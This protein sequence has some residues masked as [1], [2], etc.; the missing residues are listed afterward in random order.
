MYSRILTPLD[1]SSLSEQVLPYASSLA[2][3]LSLPM[4]LLY[5]IEPEVLTI[6]RVVNPSLHYEEMATHR[7]RHARNYVDPVSDGLQRAGVIVDVEIPQGEPAESIVGCA[8]K[9]AAT[10]ITMSSHGRSGI[11]RWWIG[12]VSDKVL[13]LTQNPMLVIRAEDPPQRPPE[14]NFTRVTVPVDGSELAE[15]VLPHVVYLSSTMGLAVDLVQV[16]P[17]RDEYY[18]S[19]AIGPNEL[20]RSTPSFED[21]ISAVDAESESYLTKLKERLLNQ[22]AASVETLLLHGSAAECIAD[23]A[24]DTHDNLVA[25]TTHGRSGVGRMVLGSVAER[26]VRQSGDPVLL[27]RGGQGGHAPLTGTP[28]F[29]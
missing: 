14:S 29:A 25:M 16:N 4:T 18:R 23:L 19:M 22:G 11:S 3:A 12:S 10:L 17:S 2:A 24:A 28:A 27:V 7:I 20:A 9:D 21:F 8:E 13:H 1:G 15:E 6:P 26:V 5:A